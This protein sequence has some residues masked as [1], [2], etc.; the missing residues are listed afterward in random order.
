MKICPKCHFQ[1]SKEDKFCINCGYSFTAAFNKKII[2]LIVLFGIIFFSI[3]GFIY[4]SFKLEQEYLTPYFSQANCND[5]LCTITASYDRDNHKIIANIEID[6]TIKQWQKEVTASNTKA[7][8]MFFLPPDENTPEN[9]EGDTLNYESK[10]IELNV[11]SLLNIEYEISDVRLK[12]FVKFKKHLQ[13]GFILDLPM[14]IDTVL[15]NRQAAKNEYLAKK[16]RERQAAAARY[17]M[18]QLF[19]N[20]LISPYT[21]YGGYYY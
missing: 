2:I 16:E 5:Q 8:L 6:E 3:I 7:N 10:P 21:Y 17:H 20:G 13:S 15:A 1:V 11:G 4:H 19:M 14:A 12:D 18:R 9:S